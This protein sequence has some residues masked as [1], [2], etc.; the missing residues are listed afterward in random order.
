MGNIFYNKSVEKFSA[1]YNNE[2]G[3][4]NEMKQLKIL[5]LE[6]FWV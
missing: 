3:L 4:G 1:I 6:Q 2:Y 5:K